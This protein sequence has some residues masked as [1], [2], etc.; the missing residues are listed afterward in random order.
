VKS[1]SFLIKYAVHGDCKTWFYARTGHWHL[2]QAVYLSVGA[3][4]S[5]LS[6]FDVQLV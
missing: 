5:G 6:Y 2:L 3:N 4:A 1:W